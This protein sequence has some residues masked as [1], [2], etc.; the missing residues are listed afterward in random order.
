VGHFCQDLSLPIAD[1]HP[2]IDTQ[3]WFGIGWS[4]LGCE[5]CRLKNLFLL[6]SDLDEIHGFASNLL[7]GGRLVGHLNA[8]MSAGAQL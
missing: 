2:L 1:C 3:W 4:C 8:A 7:P 6:R 5:K